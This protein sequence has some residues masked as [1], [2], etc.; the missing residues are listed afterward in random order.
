MGSEFP[1][2][3]FVLDTTA[4][5]FEYDTA[6]TIPTQGINVDFVSVLSTFIII[7]PCFLIS[8]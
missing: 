1:G 4:L 7:T 2:C 6:E 5:A 3:D 8:C